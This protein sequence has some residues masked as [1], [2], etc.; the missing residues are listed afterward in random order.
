VEPDPSFH[1][2]PGDTVRITRGLFGSYF[3]SLN[4]HM[5]TRV[6]RTQ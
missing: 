5:N 2:R 1:V 6:S 4:T 3:M